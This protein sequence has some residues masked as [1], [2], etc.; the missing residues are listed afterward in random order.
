MGVLPV[1][2]QFADALLELKKKNDNVTD[3]AKT[4]LRKVVSKVGRVSA[5][6]PSPC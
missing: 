2:Q 4:A 1:A 6:S 5:R 3:S